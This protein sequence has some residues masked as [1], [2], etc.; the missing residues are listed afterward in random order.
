MIA[1]SHEPNFLAIK[2][3]VMFFSHDGRRS[4]CCIRR[5]KRKSHKVSTY[6]I[7]KA[8]TNLP[9]IHMSEIGMQTATLIE[10]NLGQ[11]LARRRQE[12]SAERKEIAAAAN[13]SVNYYGAIER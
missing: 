5:N 4:K 7:T 12:I 10:S 8:I 3:G 1:G 11:L 13:I 9:T 6:P 2:Q